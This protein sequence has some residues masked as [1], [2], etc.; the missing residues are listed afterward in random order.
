LPRGALDSQN[1]QDSWTK[2][3][4]QSLRRIAANVAISG[5]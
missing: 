1:E 2:V 4:Y 5:A 3:N